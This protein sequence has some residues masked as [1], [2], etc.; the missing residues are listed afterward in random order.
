[1]I[2]E[3]TDSRVPLMYTQTA[4]YNLIRQFEFENLV[5]WFFVLYE[6]RRILMFYLFEIPCI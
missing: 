1:M 5:D 3:I 2:A 6:S 4:P